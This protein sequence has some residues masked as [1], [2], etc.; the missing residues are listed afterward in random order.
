LL[1]D[2]LK[3]GI[4]LA[5]NNGHSQTDLENTAP[6]P[7]TAISGERASAVEQIDPER[8]SSK[9][10]SLPEIS[11]KAPSPPHSSEQPA[12][13]AAISPCPAI[14]ELPAPE[15][16]SQEAQTSL[17]LQ[18]HVEVPTATKRKRAQ[19][20][21]ADVPTKL[22]LW[23]NPNLA[24]ARKQRTLQVILPDPCTDLEKSGTIVAE[25]GQFYKIFLI[26]ESKF[27]KLAQ[28]NSLNKDTAYVPRQSM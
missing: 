6:S 9:M 4:L 15:S 17:P 27:L 26:V 12:P 22:L 8:Q 1:N 23:A 16:S 7:T 14:E 20:P 2:I 19:S 24:S 13:P 11:P 10:R 25:G 5:S 28:A 18:S 21:T 3:K